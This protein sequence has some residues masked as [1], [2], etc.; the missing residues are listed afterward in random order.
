M[1]LRVKLLG[2]LRIENEAGLPSDLMKW[3]KGC[4]LLAYLII[5]AEPQN[6]EHLAD[7]L[8]DAS[9]TSQSLQNLRKL[10]SRMRKWVPNLEVMRKQVAYPMEAAASIDYHTLS[11]ILAFGSTEEIDKALQRHKAVLLH[12]FY[13]EDAPRF[14]EWL[15]LQREQLRQRVTA[16]F[17]QLCFVYT[18]KGDWEKGINAAQP[19][20]ALDEFDEEALRHLLQFLAASGQVEVA[21]QQ[22]ETS[23]QRLWSE[24]AVEPAAETVQLAQRLQNL[25]D[26]QG[27]GLSWSAIVGAQVE[28]PSPD[29]L[30]APGKLP[31][32]ALIPY[33]RNND[34][35]GRHES[36]LQLANWLLPNDG[37]GVRA[38]AISGMGGLG[39]TQLAVEFC[40]RYGRYF[41]GGVFW[42][43]FADAENVASE[44]AAVGGEHGLGLYQDTEQLSLN[45]QVGRVKRAWQ[46]SI[47]RLL[48]FD[49]CED[50]GLLAEWQP[51]TGECRVLLTSRRSQW[52]RELQVSVWPL[53]VLDLPESIAFLQQ[54]APKLNADEAAEIATEVGRLPLALHL[55]G[56]F[57]HRY[58]QISGSQYLSQL[59]NQGLVQHPSLKGRGIRYSPTGHELNV[60]RTFTLNLKKLDLHDE[61]DAM[62][63]QLLALVASF[64]PGEPIPKTLLLS[65]T[66]HEEDHSRDDLMVNLLFEDGLR[67][68]VMVGFLKEGE[69]G[70]VVMHRLVAASVQETISGTTL[71]RAQLTVENVIINALASQRNVSWGLAKIAFS[72]SHLHHL[73]NKTNTRSDKRA[74]EIITLWADYLRD[75]GAFQEAEQQY[76]RCLD[77]HIRW[78]GR[79]HVE[80]ANCLQLIGNLYIRTGLYKQAQQ[81]LEQSLAVFE[82]LKVNNDLK[83]ATVLNQLG[84]VHMAQGAY[85]DSLVNMNR[86]QVIREQ[87]F[88][89]N[90]LKV[91]AL[92]IN[93]GALHMVWGAYDTAKQ[94]LT[95]AL[96]ASEKL[97]GSEHQHVAI[98]L[99][100]LGDYYFYSGDQETAWSMLNRSLVIREQTLGSNHIETAY[101]LDSLG[102]LLMMTDRLT[103]AR[104]YLE[105]VLTIRQ[106]THGTNHPKTAV[107]LNHMG[108][109]LV[110]IGDVEAGRQYLEEAL[111]I[112][113]QFLDPKHPDIAHNLISF[114]ALYQSTGDNQ[115]AATYCER[116]LRILEEKVLETHF[117]L[118][119]VRVMM[120]QL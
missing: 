49:N 113:E 19:W 102:R 17:R 83:L 10:L 111:T 56:G 45:D 98:A 75:I 116:A 88:G 22:Y 58:Q 108:D 90:H 7:L 57:L 13:L 110:R 40:Y 25:K 66:C 11:H 87:L 73:A 35:T 115:Q 65:A 2:S 50:E 48:I 81:Y 95:H 86:G 34:F 32:N 79:D 106:Q 107:S 80:T 23:R 16:A 120:K 70:G 96:K 93:L 31:S 99:N 8:W 1:S 74:V 105:K 101:S 41:P 114:A 103:E 100:Y 5:T 62:A 63:Q 64:A 72:P 92:L 36:L 68:L 85:E 6:R 15:L 9:S 118:Q 54:L 78:V 109:L 14:N 84:V 3:Q 39:K 53:Q 97:F 18:E 26:E 82:S 117:D 33:Q 61:V 28:R 38:V 55:A 67:R 46:E 60:A 94:I 47:P 4:A 27:S 52:S 76:H 89:S 29:Q 21:M 77:T 42:L 51:A 12:D 91:E 112:L 59:R 104:P 69:S 119:R 37:E 24:L 43:S 44:V 30:S 20:L 71:N